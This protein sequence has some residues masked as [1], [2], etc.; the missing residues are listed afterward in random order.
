MA[1]SIL[2]SIS[3]LSDLIETRESE[4]WVGKLLWAPN[5]DMKLV[6]KFLNSTKV[7]PKYDY[8]SEV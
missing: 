4:K 8:G 1:E 7:D 6:E 2:S 3:C 5:D